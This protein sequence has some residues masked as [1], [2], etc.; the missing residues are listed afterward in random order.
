MSALNPQQQAAVRYIDGP[1][2]VLA[3]AGS[4]KTRVI[5]H[6]IAYLIRDCGLDPARI[7]AVTFTNKAAREMKQRVGR[8]LP[9]GDGRGLAVSTFHALGLT[10]LRRECRELGYRPG[11]S[12]FDARDSL[13]LIQEI[14]ADAGTEAA[15]PLQAQISHWKSDLI[16]PGAAL[17]QAAG[18]TQA[19]AARVY[20]EYDRRL[21]A[22]NAVDFDDL[23]LQPLRL[24][25][26]DGERLAR[27]QDRVR[28]LL[29]D[30]Y[31]DTNT[32][33]Y[34]LVRALAGVRGALTVV[35]D[36]DQ[37]IYAWRGARPGNLRLLTEDYPRLRLIKLEQNYRSMRR[38]LRSA[39]HLIA[40]NPHVF[41]KRLWSDLGHGD[42]IRVLVCKTGEHE[43]ERVVSELIQHRFRHAT[44]YGDYAVLYRGNHQARLFEQRLRAHRI[45]YRLGGGPSF[46]DQTEVKDLMAY[47]RLLVNPDD[48]A[49]F[50]R[51]VNTPRR[52]IGPTTLERLAE[53]AA[54]RGCSLFV[55]G[56]ELGLTERLGDKAAA[57]VRHFVQALT[58]YAGRAGREDPGALVRE[59]VREI[60]YL[61]WLQTQSTDHR[62]AERRQ[63]NVDELLDWLERMG[64]DDGAA[65]LAERVAR[66]TLSDRLER[67]AEEQQPDAVSLLTL[68]AAKGL[69]FPHVFMVGMEEDLLPH[70][71]SLLDDALEEERRLAYVGITRAQRSLVVTLA[72]RRRRPG[73]WQE[74]EPSRFMAELPEDE[75]HWEGEGRATSPEQRQAQGSAQLALLRDMLA[76]ASQDTKS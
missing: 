41:E 69:E 61:Q 48:D 27:W 25:R 52:E 37:S 22:Y 64:S 75:L 33:Q 68:H 47:L 8:L 60:R 20:A 16:E 49:A 38:I 35:G 44:R 15:A 19:A 34:Q 29:V 2:L 45:P 28:Y 46:F 14:A 67:N 4:G 31:Q 26:S 23:I 59:L 18:E 42:P 6:K 30:E 55:A 58:G 71:N 43:A 11:F 57:R 73:E 70:R 76:G 13:Q 9:A 40:R 5:A 32:C 39:N 17:A 65:S 50:L 21:K 66:M 7:V 12:L 36:D 72:R 24:L 56:S 51:A 1:L 63:R 3:G 62:A 74:C 53:Y 10:I 54:R